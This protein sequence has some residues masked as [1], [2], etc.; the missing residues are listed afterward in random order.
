M[1]N[2]GQY[3]YAIIETSKPQ[4]P[5]SVGIG[6]RG[7]KIY[8]VHYSDLAA[9]VSD[10][11]IVKYP[12]SR[13]NT[14]THQKV[15][16]EVMKQFTLLPVRY[17]TIAERE[18]D[19]KE[20]VLKA[21]YGEFKNLLEKM[22]D[23]VELGVR[24]FWTNVEKIFAEIVAENES[25]GQLKKKIEEIKSEQQ[26]YA[27]KI[28]IGELVKLTLE[29]KKKKEAQDLLEALQSLAEDWRENRVLGD[30]NILNAAFLVRKEK[31]GEFDQKI[32]KLQ[33]KFS[34]RTKLNY[35]GPI[36]PYNFVEVVVTW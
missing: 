31:E 6:G 29:E 35:F 28:K 8:T 22:T 30:R 26:A 23:K 7:D 15:L 21:R 13:E 36:P 24:A 20:K 11:P 25:I 2:E 19:I 32:N 27:G 14:I 17:C 9:V 18:E 33:E 12:V 1:T 4:E 3:I 34:E 10:S 5:E 16:E